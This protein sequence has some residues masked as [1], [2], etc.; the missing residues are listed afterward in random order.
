MAMTSTADGGLA[1]S[2]IAW[3]TRALARNKTTTIKMGMTVQESKDY[4][5]DQTGDDQNKTSEVVNFARRSRKR[6]EDA[7]HSMNG[8]LRQTWSD[9]RQGS[10]ERGEK[11][12]RSVREMPIK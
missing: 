9:E 7:G 5:E 6:L 10:R 2:W 11:P 3:M 4:D 1:A 8:R 12:H